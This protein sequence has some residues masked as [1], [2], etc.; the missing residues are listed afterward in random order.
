VVILQ[1][2]R[3][4]GENL[5]FFRF[6][7]VLLQSQESLDPSRLKNLIEELQELL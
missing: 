3:I 7:H 6:F 2:K 1:N 5:A 4:L